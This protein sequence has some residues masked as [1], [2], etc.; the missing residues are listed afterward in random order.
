[1]IV[2]KDQAGYYDLKTSNTHILYNKF[3]RRF[4]NIVKLLEYMG[5]YYPWNMEGVTLD[6]SPS[7]TNSPWKPWHHIYSNC[8]AGKGQTHNPKYNNYGN[9]HRQSTLEH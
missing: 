6:Y 3:V 4:S 7:T 5:S 8:K 2:Y 1:M 9:H